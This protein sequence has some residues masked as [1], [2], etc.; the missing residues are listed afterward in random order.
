MLIAGVL[1]VAVAAPRASRGQDCEPFTDM[2]A[3]DPFCAAALEVYQLDLT[4]GITPTAFGPSQ[5]VTRAALAGFLARGH[6]S[7]AA[8]RHNRRAA[9]DQ[10]WTTQAGPYLF[11]YNSSPIGQ[12]PTSIACDASDIWVVSQTTAEVTRIRASDEIVLAVISVPDAY[13]ILAA[14]GRIFVATQHGALQEI[15]PAAPSTPTTV[16]SIGAGT[17]ALAFDGARI[18]SADA[19]TISI[20]TPGSPWTV[21]TKA[22]TGTPGG[23]LFDGANIWLVD[24]TAGALL[25]LDASGDV[26]WTI[27]VGGLPYQPV[28]DGANIWVPGFGSNGITVVR[29]ATGTVVAE[30][31]GNGLDGPVAAAYD[32]ERVLVTNYVGNSVSLWR[33]DDLAPLGSVAAI[34]A[35]GDYPDVA[36]SNGIDFF[37]GMHEGRVIRF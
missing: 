12:F 30:L 16:A 34:P 9:L 13:A 7:G 8:V 14:M 3:N 33:A 11:G 28:F 31:T 5:P 26:V 17:I 32:G 25:K 20:A 18:W 15:D 2:S 35:Q 23:I 6:R 21:A 10:F 27:P 19:T 36:C 4:A 29:A 37:V 1:L 24:N 22:T